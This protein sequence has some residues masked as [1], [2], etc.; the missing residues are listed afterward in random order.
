MNIIN[1]FVS[2]L[3]SAVATERSIP[4][5]AIEF[6]RIDLSAKKLTHEEEVIK[7]HILNFVIDAGH[8]VPFTINHCEIMCDIKDYNTYKKGIER[9]LKSKYTRN[10]SYS[11]CVSVPLELN[12]K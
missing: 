1:R 2:A 7:S 9:Y 12:Q 8:K 11:L 10:C 3:K 4:A 6:K 5:P